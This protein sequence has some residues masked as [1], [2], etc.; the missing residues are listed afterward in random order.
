M[1]NKKIKAS[2]IEDQKELFNQLELMG[3]TDIAKA[4]GWNKGKVTV[5]VQRGKIPPPIGLVGGRPVWTRKQLQNV[6]P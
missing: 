1:I 4:L 6:R 2:S 3:V 5:Y